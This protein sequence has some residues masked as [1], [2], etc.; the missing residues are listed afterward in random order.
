MEEIWK[1]IEG[2]NGDYL[3]S[4]FGEIIS[5]KFNKRKRLKQCIPN[6]K[7][8]LVVRLSKNKTK[9]TFSVHRLVTNAFI[10]NPKNNPEV[11]HIDGNKL[12]NKV[13]NLEWVSAKENIQHAWKNSLC[14]NV[15][16][17]VKVPIY[18]KKL[19]LK[20]GSCTEAATY[21]QT[22]YFENTTLGCLQT[23]ISR[24]LKNKGIKSKFDFSWEYQ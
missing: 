5:E 24:L 4:N 3:I 10:P 17:A 12:N 9:K 15:R 20:F 13:T 1:E 18:S 21:I 2:Y 7:G 11:N 16:K 22:H 8:Y 23:N 6:N 19:D 14:E